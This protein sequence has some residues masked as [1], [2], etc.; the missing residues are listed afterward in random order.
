M[1]HMSDNVRRPLTVRLSD[2]GRQT[3]RELAE[4]ET[5]GNESAM[6]RRLLS[7]ALSARKARSER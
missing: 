5:E 7:E 2:S 4:V 6:V 1:A 3:V